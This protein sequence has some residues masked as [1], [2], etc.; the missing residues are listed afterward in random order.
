MVTPKTEPANCRFGPG[1]AYLAIGG[2]AV[3]NIVPIIGKTADSGFWQIANPNNLLEKCFVSAGVTTASGDL[4]VVPIVGAP[5]TRVTG[6]SA[7]NPDDISVPGC[8]G[9]ILPLSL[10]GSITV[11]GP[12]TVTWHFETQQGGV[13]GSHTTTIAAFGTQTVSDSSFT[14]SSPY[15]PGNYWVKLVV[16]APNGMTGQSSYSISCP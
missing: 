7:D 13:H 6:V 5:T 10:S 3:G 8:T 16:T 15:T 9:P 11:N 2:L 12:A 14:P 1:T 4:S